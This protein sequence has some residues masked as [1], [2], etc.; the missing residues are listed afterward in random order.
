MA[1]G[2][3]VGSGSDPVNTAE[4]FDPTAGSFASTGRMIHHRLDHTATLLPDGRVL[5]AGGQGETLV[6]NDGMFGGFMA[7]AYAELYDPGTGMFKATGSMRE[8]RSDHLAVPLT[9]GRVLIVGGSNGNSDAL[10]SAEVYDPGTGKFKATGSMHLE[11][12]RFTAT[13]MADGRVLIVGGSFSAAGPE[14]SAEIYDPKTGRFTMTGSLHE[15][16]ESHLAVLLLDGRVLVAGGNGDRGLLDSTEIYD[17]STGLFSPGN[18]M[19]YQ[20]DGA[21]AVRLQVGK[22]LF[23]GGEAVGPDST[24]SPVMS[25]ELYDPTSQRFMPAGDTAIGRV[26]HTATLLQDGRVLIA[27]G[28]YGDLVLAG[29]ELFGPTLGS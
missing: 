26:G 5:I 14:S 19:R 25:A 4:L 12:T 27:G 8:A 17:P 24:A 13:R 22:V 16:R 20:R 1:G 9:D 2:D 28:T 29:T 10:A 21:V 15:G 11:R 7:M 6:P 23:V 3:D 18:P